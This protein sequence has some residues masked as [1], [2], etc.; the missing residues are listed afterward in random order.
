ME[1][2]IGVLGFIIGWLLYDVIKLQQ[3]SFEY[4]LFVSHVKGVTKVDKFPEEWFGV[5]KR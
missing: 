4:N 1:I 3:R 2:T 5:I